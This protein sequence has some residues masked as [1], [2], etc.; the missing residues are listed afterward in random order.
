MRIPKKAA[1][2]HYCNTKQQS[3]KEVQNN[4]GGSDY[5]RKSGRIKSFIFRKRGKADT[6]ILAVIGVVA[7]IMSVYSYFWYI[8]SLSKYYVNK[9]KLI[10]F[11]EQG[12][13]RKNVLTSIIEAR[14]KQIDSFF[15][16]LEKSGYISRTMQD[17]DA[18]VMSSYDSRWALTRILPWI[19]EPER[20][21]PL[22][23][24]F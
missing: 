16:K 18:Q 4:V 12:S 17:I 11:A 3:H 13:A 22:P 23:M 9:N 7:L 21:K 8:D 15:D 19:P 20:M 6:A 1:V 2:C 14:H 10:L 5:V 24:P